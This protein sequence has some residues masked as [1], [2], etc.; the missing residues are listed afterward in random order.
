MLVAN[1][2]KVTLLRIDAGTGELSA[3]G[4]SVAAA[5]PLSIA[6]LP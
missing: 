5:T 4:Q 3:T 6:F 2:D 1:A